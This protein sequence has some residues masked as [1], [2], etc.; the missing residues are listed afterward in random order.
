MA[1]AL[2]VIVA[3]IAALVY[4]SGILKTSP[5]KEVDIKVTAPAGP[6]APAPAANAAPAR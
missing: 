2:V 3:I 1:I 6:A 5:K 4:Y